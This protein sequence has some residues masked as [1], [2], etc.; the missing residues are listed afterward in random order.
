MRLKSFL[1]FEILPLLFLFCIDTLYL[2]LSYLEI[3]LLTLIK[4]IS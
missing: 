4:N 1:E 3:T 2:F